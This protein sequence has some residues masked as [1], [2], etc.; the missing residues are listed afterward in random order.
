MTDKTIVL[1][2]TDKSG[3]FKGD[4]TAVFPCE[5]FTSEWDMTCY[6]HVGQHSACTMG[7]YYHTTRPAT[8]EE[9]ADLKAELESYGPPDAH[10]VLD[11][12]KRMPS[13]AIEQR[14]AIMRKMNKAVNA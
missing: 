5:P 2:R 12:R 3:P 11:V 1:F 4:V 6:A 10:Y 8:P 9:Y 13:D 7:W 14:R